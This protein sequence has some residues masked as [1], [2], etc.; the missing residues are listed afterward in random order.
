MYAPSLCLDR[1]ARTACAAALFLAFLSPCLAVADSPS[2]PF[3]GLEPAPSKN[4]GALYR[5]PDVDVS[6]YTRL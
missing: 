1:R 4:V 6:A 3:P 5:R 2:S